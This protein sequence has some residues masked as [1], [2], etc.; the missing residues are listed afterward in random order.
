M[1]GIMLAAGESS[2]LPN[3]ALLPLRG[4]HGIVIESGLGFLARSECHRI[5]VVTRGDSLLPKVLRHRGWCTLGYATAERGIANAILA[6]RKEGED[7]LI[8]FCD[9]VFSDGELLMPMSRPTSASIRRIPD[10]P[11]LDKYNSETGCW[12]DRRANMQWCFAGWCFLS[13]SVKN[14]TIE[15]ASTFVHLLNL[16]Q[17]YGEIVEREWWDVGTPESYTEYLTC[18]DT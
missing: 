7:A 8:T 14:A 15:K 11:H 3:K 13:A 18:R 6:A 5:S 12:V 1:H 10:S 16:T 9:N 17:A 2:R 4:P